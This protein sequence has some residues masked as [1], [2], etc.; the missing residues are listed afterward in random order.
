AWKVETTWGVPNFT[1]SGAN[2]TLGATVNPGATSITV[3][4][5]SGIAAGDILRVGD[6][7]SVE[8]VKVDS[9]YTTGTTIPL[10]S[11]TPLNFRHLSGEAVKECTPAGMKKLG[12]L[13][14]FSPGGGI[15]RFES[16]AIGSGRKGLT[17]IR[18]GN[19]E[20]SGSIDVESSIE[21]IGFLLVHAL[22]KDYTTAGT[23]VGGGANTTLAA[24]ASAGATS[25]TVA[26][27]SGIAAGDYLQIGTGTTQE[28]VQVDSSYTT[29][30]TIPLASTT[31]LRFSHA[32]GEAVVEV[33]SPFT[34]TAKR[35]TLPAGLTLLLHY[36][37]VSSLALY[38]GCKINTLTVEA[39]ARSL[40]RVRIDFVGKAM[41]SLGENLFGS[42]QDAS[43][44]PY[45]PWEGVIEEGGNEI[46]TVESIRIGI[47]N[48]I[49]G[50]VFRIGSRFLASAQEGDG[51]ASGSFTYHF[52][53][54]SLVKKAMF[55]S[56]SSLRLKFIYAKDTNHELAFYIPRVIYTGNPHP[57]LPDKGP[58][59]DSKDFT[60]LYSSTDDTDMT[61]TYKTTE[62]VI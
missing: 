11:T 36:T 34:H 19:Y 58:I 45:A 2:T 43:H 30:T 6:D 29:G 37:D 4:S 56:E 8:F 51:R 41:Q 48:N 57:G 39:D 38:R 22:G 53:D 26:S 1:L 60:A 46:K 55:E 59:S 20:V 24:G 28:V 61:V 62:A 16:G 40:P 32:S 14:S 9:S 27:A 49:R 17:N 42:A 21:N 33:T 7:D 25:I 54:A 3:A 12:A 44:T 13:V 35:G 50:D 5:A 47:E 18:S 10:A 23:T 15:G 52:F 31:P